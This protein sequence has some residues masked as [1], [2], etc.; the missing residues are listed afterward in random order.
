M[1]FLIALQATLHHKAMENKEK[2][3]KEPIFHQSVQSVSNSDSA[4]TFLTK[5]QKKV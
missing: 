2:M 1:N 4:D 5:I 3:Q